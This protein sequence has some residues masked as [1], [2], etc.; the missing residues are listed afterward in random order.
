MP[1]SPIKIYW[2]TVPVDQN[3]CNG[4]SILDP[5]L[6]RLSKKNEML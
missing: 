5:Q 3:D 2:G 4:M 1:K 6:H